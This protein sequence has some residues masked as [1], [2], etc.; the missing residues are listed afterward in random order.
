MGSEEIAENFLRAFRNLDEAIPSL[1]IVS[2]TGM[3]KTISHYSCAFHH[4]P[5]FGSSVVRIGY[6]AILEV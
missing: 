6:G 3:N 4:V 5:A 1:L 2:R